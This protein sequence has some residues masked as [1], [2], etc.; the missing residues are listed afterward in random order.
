[1]KENK[2]NLVTLPIT[3]F[4]GDTVA[5]VRVKQG[6]ITMSFDDGDTQ[7][8][9]RAGLVVDCLNN[10][11]DAITENDNEKLIQNAN[12]F[13]LALV[14]NTGEDIVFKVGCN[15]YPGCEEDKKPVKNKA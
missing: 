4:K 6:K 9:C 15:M 7:E 14:S 5:E 8:M 10:M 13:M 2:D 1:M 12:D 11:W 3:D